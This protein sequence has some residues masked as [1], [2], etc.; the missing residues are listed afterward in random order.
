MFPGVHNNLS[1]SYGIIFGMGSLAILLPLPSL[2]KPWSFLFFLSGMFLI[3]NGILFFATGNLFV[4]IAQKFFTV[5]K[6]D[7]LT[8]KEMTMGMS[9][10]IYFIPVVSIGVGINIISLYLSTEKVTNDTT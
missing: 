10:W 8:L 2:F 6:I 4:D 1:N 5:K 7:E 3:I 9:L